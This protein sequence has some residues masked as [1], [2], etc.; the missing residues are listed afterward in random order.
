MEVEQKFDQGM[1]TKM[2][3]ITDLMSKLEG[4]QSTEGCNVD[5]QTRC[6]KFLVL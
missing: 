3:K 1:L 4:L 2:S 6:K 5:D